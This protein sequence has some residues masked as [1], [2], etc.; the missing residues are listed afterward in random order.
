MRVAL[1]LAF[2]VL[3]VGC[4]SEETTGGEPTTTRTTVA[5]T[6]PT[7]EEPT[8]AEPETDPE[9]QQTNTSGGYVD[10]YANTYNVSRDICEQFGV[11]AVAKEHGTAAEPLA[12]AEAFSMSSTE[13]RH[14]QASF[15]GCLEGFRS[16]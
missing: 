7:V 6:A 5:T 16:R 8:D 12:A 13:G 3:A 11:A 10:L 9:P 1:L 2:A 4:G 15:E 14:R